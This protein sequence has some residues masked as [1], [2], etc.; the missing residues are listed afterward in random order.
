MSNEALMTTL[1]VATYLGY[2]NPRGVSTWAKR[3]GVKPKYR[4]AGR[5]GSVN[6][7]V[8]R[9]VEEG[10]RRMLGQGTGG[11]RPKATK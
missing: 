5:K 1:D 8:R 2:S 7:Y 3:Y 6:M 10:K 11:G 9:E 4:K